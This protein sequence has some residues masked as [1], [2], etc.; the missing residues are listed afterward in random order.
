MDE[1]VF[2]SGVGACS[3]L[4]R[5]VRRGGEKRV[6][7]RGVEGVGG[8]RTLLYAGRCWKYSRD[9]LFAEE[10]RHGRALMYEV[11]DETGKSATEKDLW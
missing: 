11:Y 7:G 1:G 9:R 3:G 5:A 10:D 2:W 4:Q 8:A 6:L